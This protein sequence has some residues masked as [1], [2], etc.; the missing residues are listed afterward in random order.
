MYTVPEGTMPSKEVIR[1]A[2]EYNVARS[3]R[4]TRLA[5]YYDG[6]HEKIRN[7]IKTSGLKDNKVIVNHS[8]YITDINVGYLIGN[9]VEYQHVSEDN[10]VLEPI[11]QLYKQQT[12]S[13]EDKKWA[14]MASKMGIGYELTYATETN[15][16]KS[17]TIDPRNCIIVYDDTFEHRPLFAI[18]Y[19]A[20]DIKG[21][22][23]SVVVYTPDEIFEWD[24]KLE[25]IT[26]RTPSFFK[27]VPIIELQ[28]TENW[29]GDYEDVLS[30]IDALDILQSDRVNDKEQLVESILV[31]YGADMT[32]DQKKALRESRVVTLPSQTEGAKMEYLV[33]SLNESEVEV[34]KRSLEQDIHKI[35]MTPNLSD[36][37]FVGNSSGVA[38]KYK[39]IAF[40]QMTQNKEGFL[41]DALRKRFQL[42]N[43]YLQT[44]SKMKAIPIWDVDVIFKRNLPQNDLETASLINQLRGLVS[45]ETLVG[46]LSFINDA[47][48]EIKYAREEALD[49]AKEMADQ[50]ATNDESSNV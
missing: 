42:Y 25:S 13:N 5:N 43:N 19:R 36:E 47:T 8:R 14:R 49:R 6:D 39:L 44:N 50:F 23:A 18:T 37:N 35:S 33:K 34:L 16:V 48:N 26:S 45:D 4:Y 38:I 10:S 28:N 20:T 24:K 29:R 12:I 46:Q 7:R 31:I 30:L 22:Y 41:E 40:E 27:E 17:Q 11:L 32:P 21:E 3:I 2:I 9:P 1:E 15:Q